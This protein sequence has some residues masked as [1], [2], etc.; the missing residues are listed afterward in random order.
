MPHARGVAPVGRDQPATRQFGMTIDEDGRV[1]RIVACRRAA[2]SEPYVAL[3]T[4]PSGISPVSV[5]R[6]SVINS[7]R[8]IATI[9][10]LRVRPCNAPTRS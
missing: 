5:K 9:A 2:D 7:L 3:I 6:Q 10:I 8:A 1:P 4:T